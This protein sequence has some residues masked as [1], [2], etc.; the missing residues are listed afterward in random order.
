M[1]RR[2]F[3]GQAG[4]PQVRSSMKPGRT[5]Q[6]PSSP[7]LLISNALL[8]AQRGSPRRKE[9]EKYSASKS[10]EHDPLHNNRTHLALTWNTC[11]YLYMAIHFFLHYDV[12]YDGNRFHWIVQWLECDGI[13]CWHWSTRQ[14]Q[15]NI[16]VGWQNIFFLWK[17]KYIGSSILGFGI[18]CVIFL[19]LL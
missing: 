6:D 2:A 1:N 7:L 5:T 19:S 15:K 16:V 3:D 14:T 4:C 10:V 17:Y 11:V 13:G 9:E 18:S 8:W 12:Q